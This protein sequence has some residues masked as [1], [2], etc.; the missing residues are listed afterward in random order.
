MAVHRSVQWPVIGVVIASLAW[1]TAYVML[2]SLNPRDE[3]ESLYLIRPL[4]VALWIVAPFALWSA[5][6]SRP[7]RLTVDPETSLSEPNRLILLASLPAFF[8]LIILVGLPAACVVFVTASAWAYGES[9][10]LILAAL[11]LGTLAIILGGFIAGLGVAIPLTP[12]WW[13]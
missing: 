7:Q 4:L 13:R 11:A 3:P 9:N 12:F 1:A 8:A 6:G 2:A 10:P 5:V